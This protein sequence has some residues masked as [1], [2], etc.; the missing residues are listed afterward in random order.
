MQ[1]LLLAEDAARKRMRYAEVKA[2]NPFSPQFRRVVVQVYQLSENIH[3]CKATNAWWSQRFCSTVA[4]RTPLTEATILDWV[5]ASDHEPC[6]QPVSAA[7]ARQ[8]NFLAWQLWTEW[9]TSQWLLEQ[10]AK[11]LAVPSHLLVAFYVQKWPRPCQSIDIYNYLARIQ[12]G[13]FTTKWLRVFRRRWGVQ[14]R[15]LPAKNPLGEDEARRKARCLARKECR[16]TE[17]V[18]LLWFVLWEATRF[19][20]W[21]LPRI[22]SEAFF[23][24]TFDPESVPNLGPKVVPKMERRLCFLVRSGS[25]FGTKIGSNFGTTFW[26]ERLRAW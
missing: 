4:I 12:R 20:I 14:W 2:A 7:G 3:A 16:S 9:Q 22:D 11:G 23:G 19:A 13:Q 8:E 24:T 15:H 25:I 17:V 6:L 10:N 5:A 21:S 18:T 1:E 26:P